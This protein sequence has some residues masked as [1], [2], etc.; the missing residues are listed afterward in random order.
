[1]GGSKSKTRSTSSE[2][3]ITQTDFRNDK[4]THIGQI[5]IS[6]NELIDALGA[7]NSQ[8]QSGANALVTAN[9]ATAAV[10]TAGF[11]RLPAQGSAGQVPSQMMPMLAMA[12]LAL[13]GLYMMKGRR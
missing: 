6:G 5:G 4:S 10:A 12:A 1:M 3:T 13:G 8:A 2:D 9:Q 7:F 11:Q